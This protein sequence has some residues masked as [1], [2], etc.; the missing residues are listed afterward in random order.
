V[1]D[2]KLSEGAGSTLPDFSVGSRIAG[3][4]LE[5]LVRQ[6]GMAVVFR[7]VDD[8]LGRQVALK[9]M[10]AELAADER[11]R[12]RFIRESR[13]AAAVDDPHLIP[14]Y[15]AGQ[16]DGLLFIAMRY[17]AGGDVQSLVRRDGPLS[18]ARAAAI[19]SP[20]ASAL[21][22]AHAAGLVHRD[23]KPAN[24]LLDVRPGR[25]DHVYLADFGISRRTQSLAGL[26]GT[27]QFVG[28]LDYA[29]PEQIQG[30]KADG[31]ADQY[32]LACTAFELLSAEPPFRREDAPA[33]MWAQVT[34]PP[35]LLTSRRSDLLAAV[36]TVLARALAKKPGD[37][38]GSCREF[39]DALREGLGLAPYYAG[40]PM[41]P[42][43]SRSQPETGNPAGV[44][45]IGHLVE[46]EAEQHRT[47]QDACV[48]HLRSRRDHR[49]FIRPRS[50]AWLLGAALAGLA[51][52][53]F[54]TVAV[55]HLVG[56][57]PS[58]TR[59]AS[60]SPSSPGPSSF[61]AA[62]LPPGVRVTDD[63]GTISVIVPESWDNIWYGWDP[64]GQIP[65]ITLGTVIGQG[66]NASPNVKNW[67]SDLTTPGIFVG[68]SKLLVADHY[69]PATALALPTFGTQCDFLSQQPAASHG[70]I[71][72]LDMW[73]C[74]HSTTRYETVAL[75]PG[76]HSFI[77]FIELKIVTPADEASG[78]RALD[79]LSVRY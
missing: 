1:V 5:E 74:P 43:V 35:P 34:E 79:S 73:T 47:T 23:V 62:S 36:D 8:R 28:T 25:P 11:F 52:I 46:A 6:G 40:T 44:S 18:A 13:D 71:G 37:R 41:I 55:I 26:T 21:D 69:T 14:I 75:W 50:R 54:M 27:G 33:V 68:A 61:S 77:A 38:Y 16:A 20:V 3:Y 7:A 39:A 22:A 9:V 24:M 66:L 58:S 76:N 64:Q 2:E 17:V 48:P 10:S 31:R 57:A 70:L 72:Y 56:G 4:R 78:R 42:Q 32:A 45:G 19:I 59:P 49:G 12:Q 15:E 65:G 51:V 60:L 53:V 63:T 30:E 67:F 29:A